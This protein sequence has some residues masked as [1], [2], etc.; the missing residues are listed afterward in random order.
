[1]DGHCH[2]SGAASLGGFHHRAQLLLHV[3]IPVCVWCALAVGVAL[4]VWTAGL[5]GRPVD[6]ITRLG[7]WRILG[8]YGAQFPWT[9][10]VDLEGESI[11]QDSY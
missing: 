3:H 5:H 9:H 10:A 2:D 8:S 6:Q 4:V 7:N 11:T 1:M